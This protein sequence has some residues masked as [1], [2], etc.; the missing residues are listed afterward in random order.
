MSGSLSRNCGGLLCR[1]EAAKVGE[2]TRRLDPRSGR[3]D[4]A[5]EEGR[6]Q[7]EE[8]LRTRRQ[9][10][11]GHDGQQEEKEVVVSGHRCR[12]PNPVDLSAAHRTRPPARWTC[13]KLSTGENVIDLD[14][15]RKC[16]S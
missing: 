5:Q 2:S 14:L 4:T 11:G 12:S 1:R 10:D 15:N 9:D 7:Q 8:E 16:V 6:F 3:Q 13:S